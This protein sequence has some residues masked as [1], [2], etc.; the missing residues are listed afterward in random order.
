[1]IQSYLWFYTTDADDAPQDFRVTKG[2]STNFVLPKIPGSYYFGVVLKD[3]NEEK[4]SSE[5]II[6]RNSIT[7]V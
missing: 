1:V 6:G 7:L 5:D 4:T 3:N 2:P